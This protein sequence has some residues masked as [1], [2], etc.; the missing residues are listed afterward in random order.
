MPTVPQYGPPQVRP[1]PLSGA[2]LPVET[3]IEAFG[4]GQ[5][6][7]PVF[8]AARGILQDTAQFVQ[9]ERRKADLLILGEKR[10]ALNE[11]EQAKIYDPNTGAVTQLGKSGL[12]VHESL[13]KDYDSFVDKLG[14]DLTSDDQRNAF[15]EMSDDRRN[16]VMLWAENHALK[17]TAVWKESEFGAGMESSKERASTDP[18]T[19]SE[20][21]ANIDDEIRRRAADMGWGDKETAQE[22]RN[23]KTDL[24]VRVIRKYQS[25][26][27]DL[28]AK[29]Y[30]ESVEG[31]LDPDVATKLRAQILEGSLDGE[32]VRKADEIASSYIT[33]SAGTTYEGRIRRKDAFDLADKIKDEKVRVR[34]ESRLDYI[35]DRREKQ[36]ILDKEAAFQ[37]DSVIMETDLEGDVEE[38]KRRFPERWAAKTLNQRQEMEH[39]SGQIAKGKEP[40]TDRDLYEDLRQM[41]THE[42]T[43]QLFIEKNLREFRSRLDSRDYRELFNLQGQLRLNN[44]E[45][46]KKLDGWLK[47]DEVVEAVLD[48]HGLG[49][50]ENK[51]KR[52]EFKLLLNQEIRDLE[53]DGK[54]VPPELFEK[55]MNQMLLPGSTFRK[56]VLFDT[57]F[58]LFLNPSTWFGDWLGLTDVLLKDEPKRTYQERQEL[59]KFVSAIPAEDREEIVLG[60]Q[61]D[62]RP[63]TDDEIFKKYELIKQIRTETAEKASKFPPGL[64]R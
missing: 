61:R 63:V 25:Q 45:A 19:A 4:G 22:L 38:F 32:A 28:K 9:D 34:V 42:G 51:K 27:F 17:Q 37:N 31:D 15:K 43:R 57:G 55:T 36:D 8:Q 64:G 44:E 5:A 60:L 48:A 54:E 2:R 30:F 40:V 23:H 52:G 49:G 26:G 53:K 50:K 3:P 11:W 35:Y 13:G 6:T 59:R 47:N 1:A 58:P 46:K 62:N 20:E 33:K 18:S 41:A 39:R 16:R 29:S 21:L 12:G 10:R 24:H 14:K 7:Q 56:R